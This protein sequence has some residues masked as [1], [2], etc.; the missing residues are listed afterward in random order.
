MS[1]WFGEL[2]EMLLDRNKKMNPKSIS[3]S[4]SKFYSI[5]HHLESHLH[6]NHFLYI[7]TFQQFFL[8]LMCTLESQS[9]LLYLTHYGKPSL[10]REQYSSARAL[11]RALGEDL[12]GES[13]NLYSRWRIKLLAKK[14]I[15]SVK[16]SSPRASRLALREEV[17]RQEFFRSRRS[18]FLKNHFFTLKLFLSST[19][20]YTNDMFKFDAILSLFA[21]FKIFTSL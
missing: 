16:N 4:L 13:K 15:L 20:T 5:N 6:E 8:F 10:R 7:F 17:L 19:C 1:T 3:K 18:N 9:R 11:S 2:S 14:K 21:I 12:F